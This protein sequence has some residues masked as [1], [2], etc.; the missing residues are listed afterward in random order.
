[1]MLSM[2]GSMHKGD[3]YSLFDSWITRWSDL[4]EFDIVEIDS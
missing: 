4:V 2:N 3:D 1:M